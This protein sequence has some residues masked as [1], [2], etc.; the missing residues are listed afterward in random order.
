MKWQILSD[1]SIDV[2]SILLQNRNIADT[3]EFLNPKKPEDLSAGELEI[4]S[5]SLKKAI[6]R[7]LQSIEKKEQ[8]I[9]YG[10]YDC[11]GI[12]ATAIMWEALNNS[13][14]N[15]MPYIPDRA[16]DGYGLSVSG[17]DKLKEKYPDTKLIITVDHGIV[18]V[19]QTKYAKELGFDVIITD[20]HVPGKKLPAAFAIVRTTKLSG[21]GVAWFLALHLEGEKSQQIHLPGELLDLAALGTISDMVPLQG[22][23][24][25]IAKYGLEVLNRAK[26]TGILALYEISGLK[27]GLIGT[28][29]IGY[30]LGPRINALGRIDNAL[31]SLRL[32]CTKDK[33]KAMQLAHRLNDVNKER[34]KLTEE[35]LAHARSSLKLKVKS[36]KIL[37]ISHES[38]NQ[39]II[40]LVAGKLAEEFYRPAIVISTGGEVCK[41][42]ARSI[43]GFNIIEAIRTTADILIEAGGHPMA[44]GFS[45]KTQNLLV[46]ESRLTKLAE[47]QLDEDK[48]IKVLKIDCQI[49]L[50][51][52]NWDFWETLQKLKPFGMGNPEP[53]FCSEVEVVDLRTVGNTAKHLKLKV[54]AIKTPG[55]WRGND[56]VSFQVEEFKEPL[57]FDAIAF[58]FANLIGKV[59]LG[60]KIQIAYMLDRN[61]WNGNTTLQLKIRDIKI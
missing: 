19:K 18:A 10:D 6:K 46:L 53:V 48:L 17:L 8:I 12:S 28:Y 58:N 31:D 56:H 22:G 25:S 23:N 54:K 16:D 30:I 32:L 37:F 26:R 24:R 15:V 35:T 3:S 20:H 49:N 29:E 52:I 9:V 38:Y 36:S 45:I 50:D 21:A 41:A 44:A 7:I 59:K 2:L 60:D 27:P 13:G 43:A 55:R 39:G 14:A 1:K 42:S 61:D 11:D 4:S 34:Q 40:G 5:I 47:T 57:V 33:D 51:Q